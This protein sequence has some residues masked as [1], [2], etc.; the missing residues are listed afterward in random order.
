MQRNLFACIYFKPKGNCIFYP[1]PVLRVWMGWDGGAT[2]NLSFL[3]VRE[4]VVADCQRP[5]FTLLDWR[6]GILFS[7]LGQLDC[8]NIRFII[9]MILIFF[10]FF[11]YL[12]SSYLFGEVPRGQLISNSLV[13]SQTFYWTTDLFSKTTLSKWAV[14]KQLVCP[15]T[16]L[17]TFHLRVQLVQRTSFLGWEHV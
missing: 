6:S 1:Y 11:I 7:T 17:V 16:D 10:L 15:K 2:W 8:L 5:V 3:E 4:V 12:H 13:C 14:L 9:N